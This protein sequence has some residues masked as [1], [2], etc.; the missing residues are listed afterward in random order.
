MATTKKTTRKT[1]KVKAPTVFAPHTVYPEPIPL[2]PIYLAVELAM[3]MRP[4]IDGMDVAEWC[5]ANFHEP[6][7]GKYS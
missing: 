7:R 1:A 3:T 5:K 4:K 2:T 6:M